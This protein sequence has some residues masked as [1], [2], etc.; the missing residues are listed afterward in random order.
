[1]SVH[2]CCLCWINAVSSVDTYYDIADVSYYDGL[3]G[4]AALATDVSGVVSP[5]ACHVAASVMVTWP[6]ACSAELEKQPLALQGD[7][8]VQGFD[9]QSDLL[10]GGLDG[11]YQLAGCNDGRPAYRRIGSPPGQDRWLFYSAGFGDWD[12]SSGVVPDENDVLAYGTMGSEDACW[13]PT[14]VEAWKLGKDLTSADKGDGIDYIL[15][16]SVKIVFGEATPATSI[17]Y[18]KQ[19]LTAA[20]V[21]AE[22]IGRD[23]SIDG[24]DQS[25]VDYAQ[26]VKEATWSIATAVFERVEDAL[27]KMMQSVVTNSA[28][29]AAA[30]PVG[31][32]AE[33]VDYEVFGEPAAAAPLAVGDAVI[34]EPAVA[35]ETNVAVEGEEAADQGASGGRDVDEGVAV[36]AATPPEA[37]SS[38]ASA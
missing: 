16:R 19:P 12:I 6:K 32:D 24:T 1:L 23:V 22:G 28:G 17:M 30:A 21:V 20:E 14:L 15:L 10:P 35:G 11:R 31:A 26:V 29:G 33:P 7:L 25:E 5:R 37:A 27:T 3:D 34:A 36:V 8:V 38:T 9:S 4:N 2:C 13:L 18:D